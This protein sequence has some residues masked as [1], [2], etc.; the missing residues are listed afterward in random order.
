MKKNTVKLFILA[1]ALGSGLVATAQ[2][3]KRKER[4]FARN[5]KAIKE[6]SQ[7]YSAQFAA[8]KAE[9]LRMAEIKNWPLELKAENGSVSP[10]V[11]IDPDGNPVY[12]SSYN[13][14]AALTTRT[15]TL[16]PGGSTG[17]NLTGKFGE[18]DFMEVGMWDGNYPLLSH[19]EYVGKISPIE[20]APVLPADHPSHVLG[21]MIA[22]GIN[23]DARGMAYEAIAKV[24]DFNNDFSEMTDAGI[25]LSNH[26]YGIGQPTTSIMGKY[27]SDY[28]L[29]VD[30][31]TFNIPYYQP[32]FA[33]GNDGN[34]SAYDRMTDRSLAKNGISVAAIYELNYVTTTVPQ[35]SNFSSFGPSDDNRIKP[36]ISAKGVDVFSCLKSANDAYGPMDGTSMACPGVTGAL[37]L[38][39]Q[40]YA[41]LH[42]PEGSLEK[43]FMLSSTLRALVAHC[44]TE[45]GVVGPDPIYGWGVLNA[46]KMAN[47]ISDEG[48]T[49][50]LLENILTPGQVYEIEV[51]AL[52]GQ[53]LVATLAWTDPAPTNPGAGTIVN[54][55]LVNNLDIRV[56]KGSTTSMPWKLGTTA[57]SAPVKGDN[58]VDTIEKVEVANATG[59]YTIRVSHKGSTLLNPTPVWPGEPTP[60]AQQVYSLVITGIDAVLDNKDFSKDNFTLW[61]NPAKS[62]LNISLPVAVENGANVVVYDMQGRLVKKVAITGTDTQ[63]DINGLSAGIYVASLTNGNKTEVKKFIV[64]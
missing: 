5:E 11:G 16:Q 23:E 49:S 43:T 47:T 61:P 1:L 42:T 57:S 55:P 6:L 46:E 31:I 25:V 21:T 28:T 32:V 58:N 18:N 35:I 3:G 12:L 19:Q 60:P 33:A 7:K 14:G 26:S 29:P 45:A 56:I 34:G 9:A 54:N 52:G 38:I 13:I 4:A 41:N 30:E 40:H 24:A 53:P 27:L 63:V 51:E 62:V 15:N 44:A 39:Q 2:D 10:L 17:L 20:G 22:R 36:D 59:T 64:E 48:T 8:Q 37:T 50:M